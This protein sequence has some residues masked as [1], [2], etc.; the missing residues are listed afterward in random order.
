MKEEDIFETVIKMVKMLPT[1]F[2]NFFTDKSFRVFLI[3]LIE[4]LKLPA[5]L[6]TFNAEKGLT[7]ILG[8]KR[9]YVEGVSRDDSILCPLVL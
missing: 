7:L 3:V 1:R 2:D 6:E 8:S 4:M 9:K 5:N